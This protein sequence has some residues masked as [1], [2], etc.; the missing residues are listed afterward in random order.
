[1]SLPFGFEALNRVHYDHLPGY[2][3]SIRPILLST[4]STVLMQVPLFSHHPTT[5]V[6]T[7]IAYLSS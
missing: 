5:R 6:V 7:S 4:P 2:I 1:M 3:I